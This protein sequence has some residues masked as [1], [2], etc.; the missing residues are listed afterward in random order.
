MASGAGFLTAEAKAA[1][2][3]AGVGV[4]VGGA[5]SSGLKGAASSS[6]GG[7]WRPTTTTRQAGQ[8]GVGDAWVA[9]RVAVTGRAGWGHQHQSQPGHQQQPP[10][11]QQQ[12][13]TAAGGLNAEFCGR[14]STR[15]VSKFHHG[16]QKLYMGKHSPEADMAAQEILSSISGSS[17]GMLLEKWS[18]QLVGME[19][20]PYLLRELGNRG[21]W[22]RAL[23]GYEWMVQQGHLRSEWSKLASIMIDLF[24]KPPRPNELHE[25]WLQ[26]P[27]GL[28]NSY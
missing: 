3:A 19:D 12:S 23:Q 5:G 9:Q 10:Q 20:F 28:F 2:A 16:R 27:V 15:L 25:H 7:R 13:Q 24:N 14:R 17:T 6:R 1:S 8:H 22:E 26:P 4:V 11:S 21:E 18:H